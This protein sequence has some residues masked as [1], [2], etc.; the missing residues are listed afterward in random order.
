METLPRFFTFEESH[1]AS[2]V[3]SLPFINGWWHQFGSVV[4][5]HLFLF[6]LNQRRQLSNWNPY[7][8]RFWSHHPLIT[9]LNSNIIYYTFKLW[10]GFCRTLQFVIYV[11]ANFFLPNRKKNNCWTKVAP[12]LQTRMVKVLCPDFDRSDLSIGATRILILEQFF[13]SLFGQQK[14]FLVW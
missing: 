4:Y 5:V 2:M 8:Y 11:P 14:L 1:C 6:W 12:F 7:F 13:F 10:E 3:A 9:Q